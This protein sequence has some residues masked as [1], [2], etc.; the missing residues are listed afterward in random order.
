MDAQLCMS[1]G[2]SRG[3]RESGHVDSGRLTEERWPVL[4]S[5][6]VEEGEKIFRQGDPGREVYLIVRGRLRV[7]APSTKGRELVLRLLGP[8]DVF[9]EL[10]LLTDGR[11]SA[12]V[13]AV[14]RGELAVI[15][16]KQALRA[17]R[18]RPEVAMRLL[19]AVALRTR[20]LS[21]SLADHAFLDVRARLA[22]RLLSLQRAYGRD[23][24][25][26]IRIE[27]RLSQEGLGDMIG[28][29][30]ESVN[31]HFRQW[32]SQRVASMVGGFVTVHSRVRLEEIARE[33]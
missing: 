22:K 31:K 25:D 3:A 5:Y 2:D 20:A 28:A 9:G 4:R 17:L 12:T 10:A 30:R 14:E 19:E 18:A 6:G 13:T 8:G 16:P 27:L 11:R 15:E 23:V 7:S 29:T 1:C 21:E 33:T 24:P 32:G 26:G